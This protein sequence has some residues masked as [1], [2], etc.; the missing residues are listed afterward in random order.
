MDVDA[1]E[2]NYC[3]F[4]TCL[5]LAHQN[6]KVHLQSTDITYKITFFFSEW[7]IK[8]Q[9]YRNG[10]LNSSRSIS[11]KKFSLTQRNA[12]AMRATKGTEKNELFIRHYATIFTRDT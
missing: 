7:R 4:T 1:I 5:A 6:A 9:W 2:M 11:A 8:I 12:T 10:E 3:K